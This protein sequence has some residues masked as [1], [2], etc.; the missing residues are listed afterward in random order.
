M[1]LHGFDLD[2]DLLTGFQT[3]WGIFNGQTDRERTAFVWSWAS[4]FDF[5]MVFFNYLFGDI[6]TKTGAFCFETG[7]WSDN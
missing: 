3:V 4:Y 5:A 1:D 7:I 2:K 6:K